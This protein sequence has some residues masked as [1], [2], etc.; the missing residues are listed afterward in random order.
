[1]II[2]AGLKVYKEMATFQEAEV[3]ERGQEDYTV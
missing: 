1:M 2:E 3:S